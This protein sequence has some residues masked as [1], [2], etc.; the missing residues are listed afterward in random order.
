M[1]HSFD[2][3]GDGSRHAPVTGSTVAG[4][5]RRGKDGCGA[6]ETSGF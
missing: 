4:E 5:Q 1:L 3:R 2:V 6:I